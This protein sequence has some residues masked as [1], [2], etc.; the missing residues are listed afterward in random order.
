MKREK[1][2]GPFFAWKEL[3]TEN[4]F[5]FLAAFVGDDVWVLPLQPT[6]GT[7]TRVDVA[8]CWEGGCSRAADIKQPAGDIT[9]YS[10]EV[11]ASYS[12][13]FLVAVVVGGNE[14]SV[15]PPPTKRKK[16]KCEADAG[17]SDSEESE[18]AVPWGQTDLLVR[19]AMLGFRPPMGIT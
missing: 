7:T 6:N 17:E 9:L 5:F 3:G 16:R 2:H 1:N 12:N 14:I 13:G 18:A 15:S 11:R 10:V 8:N 4:R 19:L